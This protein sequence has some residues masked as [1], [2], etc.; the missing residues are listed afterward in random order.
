MDLAILLMTSPAKKFINA[1]LRHLDIA[2]VRRSRL[3]R[4][5]WLSDRPDFID[6]LLKIPEAQFPHLLKLLRNSKS[7]LRQ[8]LF[9]LS[10]LNMKTGGFFVEFGA[11]NGMDLSN[12]YLLEKELGWTG[13]VADPATCW[14]SALRENRS[15]K[16]ET[17]CVWSQSNS[18]LRF[19]EVTTP[20]LS[21]V[22][23]LS[24][25]DSLRHMRGKG[26]GYAVRTISLE[27]MLDKHGAPNIIDY[28]SVDTEGSEYEILKNFNFRRYKFRVITCEHNFSPQRQKIF[29][30]LTINGY[31]RKFERFSG[32]DD[33][34]VI[35]EPL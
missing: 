27:D 8:D 30:L 2:L 28:L 32:Y 15:C 18:I 13:I 29:D 9:A 26:I 11:T 14:H 21:T 5:E 34:Y 22:R 19:N 1:T 17:D 7:Q 10:Q 20:E 35:S 23:S 16:I 24:S 31:S 3:N 6:F 4:L 25:S 12:T 33:W